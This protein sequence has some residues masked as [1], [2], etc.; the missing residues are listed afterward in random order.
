MKID[1]DAFEEWMAHPM[2][3]ALMRACLAWEQQAETLWVKASWD[4]G[5]TDPVVLARLRE[6]ARTL[7]Q[8]RN[9]TA[10]KIEEALE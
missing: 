4:G 3:E 8:I 1:T 7:E 2:T 5:Q 10:D 9:M 6:R